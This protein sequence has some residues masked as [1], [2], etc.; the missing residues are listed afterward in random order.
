MNGIGGNGNG[1]DIVATLEMCFMRWTRPYGFWSMSIDRWARQM[2][3]VIHFQP[4]SINYI[5]F[6]LPSKMFL[7]RSPLALEQIQFILRGIEECLLVLE[8]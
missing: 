5:A 7:T 8:I 3:F 2:H 1:N 4:I 6:I